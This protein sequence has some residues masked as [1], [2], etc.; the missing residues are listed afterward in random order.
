MLVA[1]LSKQLRNEV[2]ATAASLQATIGAWEWQEA[3]V[4]GECV[5]D[6]FLAVMD[7]RFGTTGVHV[8]LAGCFPDSA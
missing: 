7:S 2:E 1:L 8:G 3:V 6:S 5:G 4:W